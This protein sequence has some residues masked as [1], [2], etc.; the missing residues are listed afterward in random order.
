[1]TKLTIPLYYYDRNGYKIGPINK[2]EL[3]ALA[4]NGTITPE[5]RLTDE[6]IEFQAKQIPKLKFYTPEYESMVLFS[7][8][9]VIPTIIPVLSN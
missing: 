9:N 2:K 6:K 7:R 8:S 5:T 1:M 3:Y 4:E